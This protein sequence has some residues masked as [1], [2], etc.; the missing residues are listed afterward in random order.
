MILTYVYSI[1][2]D[3]KREIVESIY[4]LYYKK[5]YA[6]A[7]DIL[8]NYHDSLDALQDAFYN[9]T[10]TYDKFRKPKDRSTAA[11]VHI[12]TKYAAIN[13]YNRNKRYSKI[14]DTYEDVYESI[15]DIEDEEADVEKIVIDKETSLIVSNAVDRLEDMY[16]DVIVL[17]YYYHMKNIHIAKILNIE[18][19]K[20]NSRIFRAK[21]KLRDILGD[22]VYERITH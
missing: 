14:V 16:R 18:T 20:V 19:G 10:A 22:E 9:I 5:M 21:N 7:Y 12:Y 1:E 4:N 13:I 17:K 2:D 8:K 11:L 15:C 6:T 3:D